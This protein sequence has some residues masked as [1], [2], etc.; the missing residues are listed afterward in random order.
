[1]SQALEII[2]NHIAHHL[3]RAVPCGRGE[4][5]V[6]RSSAAHYM[7]DMDLVL[8]NH[9]G[10]DRAAWLEIA[11]GYSEMYAKTVKTELQRAA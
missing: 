5:C 10:A 7:N 3:A 11:A 4:F 2:S 6:H 1:M 8:E 9:R